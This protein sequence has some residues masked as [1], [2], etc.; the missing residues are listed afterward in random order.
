LNHAQLH[1][2][3]ARATALARGAALAC[4]RATFACAT[5][6]LACAAAALAS[7]AAVLAC[8]A[9]AMP[10]AAAPAHGRSSDAEAAQALEATLSP[11]Q[12]PIGAE[13]AVAGRLTAGTAGIGAAGLELQVEGYPFGAFSTLART[14][15]A[16]DGS[17]SFAA[18][19]LDRN[20]RLRVVR[21]GQPT[22]ASRVL[23]AIVDPTVALAARALGPGRTEL[24]LRLTHTT[25]VR[26]V[27]VAASWYV[28]PRRGSGFRLVAV[29]LTRELARGVTYAAAVVDPPSRTFSYRVCTNPTW[30]HAMGPRS[31]HGRCPRAPTY[32][33]HATGTPLPSFPTPAAVARAGRF[34]DARAGRTSF[35][36]MD[37]SGHVTGVRVHEHFES[38]SVVKVMMLT[39]YLQMLAARH[40]GLEPDDRALLYPMIHVSDNGAASAVLARVGEG[41][42]ARVA[43]ETGMSD[44]APG[45]GWWAFTQTSAS[46]QVRLF[47]ALRRLIPSRFYAYARYL[48]STIESSQSW[49]IPPVARPTWKVFFKTGELPSQGLFNEAALLERGPI[50]FAVAVFTDADPSMAYGEQTIAGVGAALLAD[51]P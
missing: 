34:L 49:G 42:L 18:L 38:A 21:E 8:A 29:T 22:I 46:D 26:A 23:L 17:F 9:A 39:A 4:T 12:M 11:A 14:V 13:D 33:G 2:A 32:E 3:A 6:T 44:Y 24:S 45:V 1:A 35:A 43:A 7:A 15:T 41:A 51:A 20:A 19:K 31:A 25:A 40:R 10:A 16:P 5:A 37:S 48:L 28:R 36:V 47:S 27:P 30:E 50:A